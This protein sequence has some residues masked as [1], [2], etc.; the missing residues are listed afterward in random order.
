[1]A[2]PWLFQVGVQSSLLGVLRTFDRRD[3]FILLYFN[4]ST[5]GEE[6]NLPKDKFNKTLI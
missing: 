3:I 6:K 4:I 1:M 2:L 5:T